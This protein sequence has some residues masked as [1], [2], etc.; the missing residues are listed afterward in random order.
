MNPRAI[1]VKYIGNYQLLVTF[2]N[3]EVKKFDLKSFLN[4]PVY[5]P[6]KDEIFCKQVKAKDGILFWNDTIDLDPDTVYLNGQP[7]N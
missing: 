5:E 2:T 3:A 1:S 7:V 4:Y 6:L